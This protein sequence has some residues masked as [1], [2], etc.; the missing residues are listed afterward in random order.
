MSDYENRALHI[1]LLSLEYIQ[2][3]WLSAWPPGYETTLPTYLLFNLPLNEIRPLFNL[4]L[5]EIRPLFNL[6][7]NEIRPLFNLP[8]NEIRPLFNLPLNEARPLF[9]SVVRNL[10]VW[11]PQCHLIEWIKPKEVFI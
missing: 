9:A 3:S 6:P 2:L 8:L 1:I 10:S 7:L 5:N 11:P 4:P